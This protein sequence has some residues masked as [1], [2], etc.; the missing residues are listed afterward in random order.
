LKR[1]GRTRSALPALVAPRAGAWIET[2]NGAEEVDVDTV[3]PRAGA[4][5][6]TRGGGGG[7]GNYSVAPRAGAWIETTSP[8]LP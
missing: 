6:E 3:A 5:I 4:W 1:E 2:I 8:A 7:R